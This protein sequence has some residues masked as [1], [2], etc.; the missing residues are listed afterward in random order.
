[1][2]LQQ[3][4]NKHMKLFRIIFIATLIICCHLPLSAQLA[5]TESYSKRDSAKVV[6]LLETAKQLKP[7]DNLV[8]HFARQLLDIPYVAKTLEK[9]P[10]E[11]SSST[12]RNSI[13]PPTWRM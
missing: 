11:G 7:N 9:F 2:H 13:A 10:K 3:N 8:I 12:S 4:N 6:E 5:G 1:M